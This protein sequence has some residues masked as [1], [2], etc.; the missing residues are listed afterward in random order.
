M[1][2][3]L[4]HYAILLLTALWL[5]QPMRAN[6]WTTHIDCEGGTLGL[7]VLQNLL[8]TF[9]VVF[10][11]TIYTNE[12]V[13]TGSQSCKMGI[14]QGSDGWSEWGAIYKFPS[15]LNVGSQLWARVSL[16]VPAGFNYTASPWLKFM[17]IHTASPSNTNQGYRD[18]YI[19]PPTGTVWDGALNKDV[20]APYSFYYEGKPLV[21]TL[22]TRP[23][24]DI[25][26]GQWETYEIYYK[27]DTV[28]KAAGGTGEI[29]IWKNNQLLAD[30]TDQTTLVDAQT[31]AESLFLFTYWNANAP[32]TQSLYVDDVIVTSDTPS[33]R[34]AAG[35]PFIGAP[36]V[37]TKAPPM[38]PGNVIA[39]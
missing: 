36:V 6:A 1:R 27:L 10:T 4:T 15:N 34:D 23:A 21:R 16:Y 17:R 31:F 9:T 18:L 12:Q 22:G 7:N 32:A 19:N 24:N 33:N 13:G 3:S 2:K 29:R 25:A 38:P 20:S 35:N 39:H 26:F 37:S 5:L 14:T 30:L 8:N 11:K 28:S